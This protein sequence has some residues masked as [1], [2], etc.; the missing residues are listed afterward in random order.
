MIPL[1]D[2]MMQAQNGRAMDVMA[3]QFGLA[4]E[5]MAKATAA[6]MPAFSA[7]LKTNAANP[8]DFGT[9]LAAMSSGGY[10]KYFEDM[11]KAFTPQGLAD[12]Q[13][14]LGQI[15]GSRDMS[16]AVA[17]QAAQ[18]TGIGQDIYRQM[19]PVVA[20]A[21]MGGLFKQATG[22]M[23][24]SPS[25]AQNPFGP[26][27]Q[28]WLE[29][30]GLARKKEA[31][32]MPNPFDNPFTQT[33]QAFFTPPK[34]PEKPPSAPDM[35]AGNPFMKAFQDMMTMGSPQTKPADAP[36]APKAPVVDMFNTMFDSGIEAQK[37]YQKAIDGL[38][39]QFQSKA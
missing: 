19:L 13:A 18:L 30:V 36:P 5:Q 23:N 27:M 31:P 8:Y 38:F 20:S 11:T 33:M 15:F 6:L 37:E 34:S 14:A 2:M 29:A 17:A 28:S 12:G 39:A 10:A 16:G 4:Q 24:A 21:I 32:A 22:Q 35:F 9:F 1:F 3:Q 26:A 25:L 7:G